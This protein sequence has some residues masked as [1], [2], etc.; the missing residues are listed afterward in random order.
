MKPISGLVARALSLVAAIGLTAL[1]VFVHATDRTSLGAHTVVARE[2][3][4]LAVA[5]TTSVSPD[6]PIALAGRRYRDRGGWR[7]VRHA[8]PGGRGHHPSLSAGGRTP[9]QRRV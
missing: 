1:L 5:P 7:R 6:A 2:A 8:T 4:H 3:T 9:D